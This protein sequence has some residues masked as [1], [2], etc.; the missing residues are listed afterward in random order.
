MAKKKRFQ[1]QLGLPGLIFSLGLLVCLFL[2]MFILGFYF[3]QRMMASR[4]EKMAS[5]VSKEALEEKKAGLKPPPV[6]EEVKPPPLVGEKPLN[7]SREEALPGLTQKKIPVTSKAA[8][9]SP[10]ES[11]SEAKPAAKE[12]GKEVKEVARSK[13]ASPPQKSVKAPPAKPFYSVQVASLRSEKEAQ[14]YVNY[15]R[16]RGYKAFY[17]RVTL[18]QK[19]TWFRVYVGRFRTLAEARRFGE[20]LKRREKLKSF[21]VQKLGASS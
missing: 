10:K 3:G 12:A 1:F 4:V 16:E 15:L 8:V 17:R 13:A 11:V 20:E 21:Y 14:R 9:P 2:W 18:P 7:E 6:F 5:P 19:G